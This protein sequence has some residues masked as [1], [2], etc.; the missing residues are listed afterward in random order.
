MRIIFPDR[1]SLDYP[2]AHFLEHGPT[3]HHLYTK[4]GGKWIASVS[5]TAPVVI[6]VD[7]RARMT[8]LGML[9]YVTEHIEEYRDDSAI[10]E[11]R[12]LKRALANFSTRYGWKHNEDGD[13]ETP[14]E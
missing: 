11:L 6:E 1:Q 12:V 13:A 2:D 3:I 5:A 10:Y 9:R 4:Q 8:P 14:Q 7:S